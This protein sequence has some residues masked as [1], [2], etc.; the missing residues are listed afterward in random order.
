M[1]LRARSGTFLCAVALSLSA[2]L[3]AFGQ[4][5]EQRAGARS[6]ATE[7]AAAFNEGRFK[8]AVDLFSR[9]ESLVHA[10]PHLLFLARAHAKL[11]QFVKAREAYLKV[12]KE[13]LPASAPQAFRDAQATAEA[14]LSAI[15]PKIGRL[16]IIVEGGDGAKDLVVKLDGAVVPAVLI[17]VPQPADPGEHR[18]EA[19]AQGFRAQ[20]QVVR[21]GEGEK[22]S[23]TLKLEV[24]PSATGSAAAPS[25][26]P[27]P[28]AG[29][30]AP[31]GPGGAA[32]APADRGTSGG[33]SNGLRIGS[34]VAFG[35]G[36]VG[37]G[38]GTVFMLQ[39]SGKDSDVDKI[40][41]LPGGACP[42]SRRDEVKGL[43][44]DASSARTLGVTGFVVGGAG[45]AAGVVL[46]ILSGS[47]EKAAATTGVRPW[48]GWNSA[49]IDGRF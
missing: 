22:G 16:A 13:A 49:G 12:I 8:D 3:P 18:V 24:D 39:A 27:A 36:A 9:A 19:S 32:P 10:P 38:L 4:T 7:G 11:N 15:E 1:K 17:G 31:P 43:E 35:V 40:C 26:E 42:E 25:G 48:I 45:V 23:V 37:L 14:E 29:P 30:G 41:T 33:G 20:P 28:E 46:F 6:L 44:E 2:S 34:Y 5:D 47:S 21:L